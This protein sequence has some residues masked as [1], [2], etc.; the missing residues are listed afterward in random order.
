M[1][2]SHWPLLLQR[3]F[4]TTI[5]S[6]TN[7]QPAPIKPGQKSANAFIQN[8]FTY[9]SH[10][11]G[12]TSYLYLG[13][14]HSETYVIAWSYS[15]ASWLLVHIPWSTIA[16]CR[17]WII[18]TNSL[19]VIW[20]NRC[21]QMR[22]P[23][24]RDTSE[25]KAGPLDRWSRTLLQLGDFKALVIYV[26]CTPRLHWLPCVAVPDNTRTFLRLK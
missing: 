3:C 5:W 7:I 21:W 24:T 17:Q 2:I 8:P 12:L 4:G 15:I 10:M 23:L 25:T 11:I 19:M 6:G 22:P 13:S 14:F 9:P 20:W 26:L 1:A 16:L 18:A